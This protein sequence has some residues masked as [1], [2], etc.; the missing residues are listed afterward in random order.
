MDL[1]NFENLSFDNNFA[2]NVNYQ[3]S[4]THFPLHWH[5]YGE[6]ILSLKDDCRYSINH[7]SYTLNAGD[8]L[9]IWPLELHEVVDIQP[10]SSLIVQFSNTL[11]EQLEEA[12][13]IRA[14]YRNYH[15][16]V[17]ARHPELVQDIRESM[18]RIKDV[19]Y[20][21]ES[22]R[23]IQICRELYQIMLILGR[24]YQ[25]FVQTPKAEAMTASLEAIQKIIMTCNHLK[26][27]LDKDISLED[28]AQYAGFSPYY[29][30]RLF[31]EYNDQTFIQWVNV[32]RVEKAVSLFADSSYSI[33]DVAMISGFKSISSFNRVFRQIKNC[34]PTEY[35]HL[36]VEAGKASFDGTN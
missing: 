31:K 28:A 21:H 22:F 35:R 27:N 11:I 10:N 23:E 29:F 4:P 13:Y 12:K 1:H 9:F 36:Y 15:H 3:D 7:A 26:Q 20:S 19:F 6:L 5:T 24:H 14:C 33:T 17:A 30:S 16:F 18:M 2:V 25:T 8:I 34:T 32:Q